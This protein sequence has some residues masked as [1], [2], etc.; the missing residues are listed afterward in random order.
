MEWITTD[1][2]KKETWRRLLEFANDEFTISRIE[3]LHGPITKKNQAAYK[4]QAKQIRLC[5]LQAQDYLESSQHSSLIT[6]PNLIY[7]CAASLC[8]ATMLLN[9]NGEKSLDHLRSTGKSNSHG[10][11]KRVISFNSS[12]GTNLLDQVSLKIEKQ[13]FFKEWY[14]TIPTKEAQHSVYHAHQGDYGK[15]SSIGVFSQASYTS[16]EDL[17]HSEVTLLDLVKRIPDLEFDL[18]RLGL[19]T[20]SSRISEEV[21]I[22]GK[23]AKRTWNIHGCRTEDTLQSIISE[24]KIKKGSDNLNFEK[25]VSDNKLSAH[26]SIKSEMDEDLHYTSPE[27]RWTTDGRQFCYP[28]SFNVPE[29]VDCFGALYLLGMVCRYYPDIWISALDSHSLSSK[30]I[31]TTVNVMRN[32]LPILALSLLSRDRIVIS[33]HLAP[34]QSR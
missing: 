9:G 28:G 10:L 16:F 30:I 2:I 25:V 33:P 1:D 19:N 7:Y 8:S 4:K 23:I 22:R 17:V 14:E 27:I 6:S 13:G 32:K 31:E 12:K 29:I 18:R 5:L 15:I 26:V 21:N 24:F 34:W 11:S 3:D 20:V